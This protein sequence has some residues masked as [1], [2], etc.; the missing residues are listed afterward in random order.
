MAWP[1]WIPQPQTVLLPQESTQKTVTIPSGANLS[2]Y[3]SSNTRYLLSGT[4]KVPQ[5]VQITGHDISYIMA[6]GT[7][8]ID[9]NTTPPPANQGNSNRVWAPQDSAQRILFDGG[10][11]TG[12]QYSGSAFGIRGTDIT[13]KNATTTD[14]QL[15]QFIGANRAMA[16]NCSAPVIGHYFMTSSGGPSGGTINKSR[17]IIIQNCKALGSKSEHIVRVWDT[18][19]MWFINNNFSNPPLLGTK[20]G[21]VLNLR[22]GENFNVVGGTYDGSHAFGPL[23]NYSQRNDYVKGVHIDGAVFTNT[24]LMLCS[25]LSDYHAKNLR[26]DSTVNILFNLRRSYNNKPMATGLSEQCIFKGSHGFMSNQSKILPNK[27]LQFA[28]CTYNGMLVDYHKTPYLGWVSYP[29]W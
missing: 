15:I 22:S 19:G 5:G 23:E 17:N 3:V 27:L 6:P 26:I 7:K 29:G 24:Y 10:E 21:Q 20:S 25:G 28:S 18:I 11:F 8:I 1:L 2:K 4:Y 13:V 14:V 9:T 16:D 12:N